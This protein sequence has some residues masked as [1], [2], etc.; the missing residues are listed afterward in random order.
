[1]SSQKTRHQKLNSYWVMNIYIS[2]VRSYVCLYISVEDICIQVMPKS[3]DPSRSL[4]IN[5]IWTF[6]TEFPTI[7]NKSC[8]YITFK[9]AVKHRQLGYGYPRG[10]IV[11]L[12]EATTQD[13]YFSI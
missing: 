12:A 10:Q 9:S 6:D 1:M 8:T 3:E 11:H 5:A 4:E 2:C 7:F 13:T